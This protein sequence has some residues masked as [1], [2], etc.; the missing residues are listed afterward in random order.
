MTGDG[1]PETVASETAIALEPI[2]AEP[3]TGFDGV[4]WDMTVTSLSANEVP[5]IREVTR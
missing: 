3:T 1:P 5:V 2:A 4:E